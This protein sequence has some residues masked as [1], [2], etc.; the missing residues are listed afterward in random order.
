[1]RVFTPG[2]T[3]QQTDLFQSYRSLFLFYFYFFILVRNVDSRGGSSS[4]LLLYLSQFLDF[5]RAVSAEDHIAVH[6]H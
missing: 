6:T 3:F 5:H 2:G 1:M 4:V